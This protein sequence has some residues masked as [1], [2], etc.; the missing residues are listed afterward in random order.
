MRFPRLRGRR[1]PLIF[2]ATVATV[3]CVTLGYVGCRLIPRPAAY[4]RAGTSRGRTP[5]GREEPSDEIIYYTS[6]RPANWDIFLFSDLHAAPRQITSDPAP[7]YDPALSPGGRWVV[8]TSDRNGN[9]DLFALDLTRESGPVQLTHDESFDDAAAFSPDGKTIAWVS[10]RG[11]KPDIYLMPFDPDSA[12]GEQNVRRLTDGPG[13]NF[14]PR[15][16]PDGNSIVFSSNR[17]ALERWNPTR[18][19]DWQGYETCIYSMKLDGSGARKLTGT[20][21]AAGRP[22]LSKDGARLYYYKLTIS[23]SARDIRSAVYA[24]N[25][26]GS[27]VTQLTPD[28]IDGKSIDALTPAPGP[29]GSIVFVAVRS[30]S[31]SDEFRFRE[32]YGGRLYEVHEDGGD[33]K[34]IGEDARNYLS[35]SFDPASGTMVAQGD[36]AAPPPLLANGN[37]LAWP[38]ARRA[39][40]LGDRHVELRA[41]RAY[42]PSYSNSARKLVAV[43]WVHEWKGE[44]RGPSPL[45]AFDPD[46]T[47]WR[48]IW[49]P[50]S[51]LAWAPAFT[52]DGRWIYFTLG[53]VFAS[54]RTNVDIWKVRSDGTGAVNLTADSNANDAFPSVSA[55]G[56]RVVFRSGRSGDHEIFMMDADGRNVR[57]ISNARGTDT[58]PAISP[59]GEWIAYATARTGKGLKIWMQR[60]NDPADEGHLLEPARADLQSIDVHPR[61]SPDGKWVI[62]ASDRAGFRDEWYLSGMFPQPYGDLFAIRADGN[63]QAI[64]LTDDKWEDSLPIWTKRK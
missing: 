37:P 31:S 51:Q 52:D 43:E 23:L 22:I 34:P 13:G 56:R 61:F 18:L 16:S 33:P 7:D 12:T 62:I 32:P 8:F 53:P 63:G 11:G 59:D 47:S 40:D 64:Q 55:D 48:P 41:L 1:W 38:H 15:F 20:L 17:A 24:A 39:V 44:P 50:D 14:N 54:P 10:T 4:D 29:N 28:S 26:D 42:F 21:A 60:A 27:H 58:M 57:Q 45:I 2:V 49:K 6:I 9:A 35:P 46:A 36:G 19:F 3:G 30:A 25:S 5:A